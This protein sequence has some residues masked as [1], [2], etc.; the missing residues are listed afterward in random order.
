VDPE[1]LRSGEDSIRRIGRVVDK[2][3]AEFDEELTAMQARRG[4]PSMR[5]EERLKGT[6][7]MEFVV[8]PL[9]AASRTA[10]L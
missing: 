7:L 6:L 8:D 5:P 1:E 3:L 9:R 10:E 4:Q 2:V